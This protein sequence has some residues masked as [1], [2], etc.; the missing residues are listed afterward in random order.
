VTLNPW[1]F[2]GAAAKARGITSVAFERPRLIRRMYGLADGEDPE[3][4]DIGYRFEFTAY[5]MKFM[6]ACPGP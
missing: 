2:L 5:A 6:R 1:R 4:K 3:D